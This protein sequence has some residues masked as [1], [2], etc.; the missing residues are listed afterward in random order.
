MPTRLAGHINVQTAKNQTIDQIPV[1]PTEAQWTQITE[2]D[3]SNL[4][5]KPLD[6]WHKDSYPAVCIVMLSDSER[7]IGGE[8]AIKKGD[9]TIQKIKSPGLGHAV[10]LAGRYT[11]HAALQAIG[12][13]RIVSVT[14]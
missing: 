9:G 4:S 12:G 3:K 6:G 7:M 14:V 1:D 10:F 8:T 2:E 11:E 5:D 13:E